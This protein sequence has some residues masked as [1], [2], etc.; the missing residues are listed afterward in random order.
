MEK[1]TKWKNIANITMFIITFSILIYFC[2]SNNN[3]LTLLNVF[4][5][6]NPYWLAFAFVS[7]FLTWFLDSLVLGYIIYTIESKKFSRFLTFKLTMVGQFFSSITPL[8]VG[9]QPM[10]ILYLTKYGVPAGSAVSILVKKFLTYQI[11]MVFYSALV[12]ITKFN[13]FSAKIPG[14]IALSLIGFLSQCFIVILLIL[15]YINKN[16]TYKIISAFSCLLF[17]F[18][19][20]KNPNSFNK[21]MEKQLNLFVESNDAFRGNKSLNAKLYVVTFLQFTFLF[22]IPF[23]IFKSFNFNGLP[24]VN[25]VSTQAFVSMIS[26]YTPLPGAAGVTEGSFITLFKDFFGEDFVAIAML[27]C[28]LITYYFN[29]I[30]GFLIIKIKS[31]RPQHINSHPN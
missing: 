25:M 19:I 31:V 6:L 8:G 29:I 24:I 12:I 15:F 20:I 14:F 27:L 16:F 10:Q 4:P 3:L 1:K 13:M 30:I 9:G 26:S 23:F 11:T 18:K 2:I 5:N 28:R 22:S 7:M 17:K 21:K